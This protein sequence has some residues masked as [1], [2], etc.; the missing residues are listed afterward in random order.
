[1]FVLADSTMHAHISEMPVGTY[2]KGHRHG[3]SLHVMCVM[4]Q[5]Y[6]LL[7]YE[8]DKDFRRIDWKHGMVLVPADR[9]FHQHFNT[10]PQPARYLATAVGGMRYP[11]TQANRISL[12]RRR[13]RRY[14]GGVEERQGRRRPDRIRGS[15]SAHPPHLARRDAQERRAAEDGEIRPDAGGYEGWLVM[16]QMIM[17]SGCLALALSPSSLR[18]QRAVPRPPT[19][20]LIE[21]AKKEGQVVWYTT[22][23]VNQIIRPL[24]DAFEKKYPGVTMQ[25]TRADDL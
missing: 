13:R 1:M 9:Q 21:A 10:G 11:T 3:P 15:G 20:A 25:Y 19:P 2:K 23:I 6:S 14:A 22:L 5:G 16:A 17:E 7:W 24:K 4:G 12:A 8:H 18:W